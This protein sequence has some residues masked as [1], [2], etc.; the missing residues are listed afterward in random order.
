MVGMVERGERRM[1]A[2]RCRENEPDSSCSRTRDCWM[3]KPQEDNFE[4]C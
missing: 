1:M 3:K 4:M 2:E